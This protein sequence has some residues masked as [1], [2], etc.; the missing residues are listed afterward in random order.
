MKRIALG[1]VLLL[2]PSGAYADP[3]P[4]PPWMPA[5]RR[6]LTRDDEDEVRH[7][8]HEAAVFGTTGLVLLA[9]GVALDVVALDL[10]QG[11]Q[12][13]RQPDGNI[14]TARVRNDANWAE[15]AGGLSLTATGLALA[16]IGYL[17]LKQA[18]KLQANE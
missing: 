1:L 12:A 16:W 2:A 11:E 7:L 9:G 18:R 13:M 8:K 3:S 15:L 10:P 17:K 14:V 4:P 6:P 5:P